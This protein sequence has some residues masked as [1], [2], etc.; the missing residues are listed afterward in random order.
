MV[1]P[2]KFLR[3]DYS[4]MRRVWVAEGYSAPHESCLGS[5]RFWKEF[6]VMRGR[7][8]HARY[9]KVGDY[10][11]RDYGYGETRSVPYNYDW[12]KP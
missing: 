8:T 4:D 12:P 9:T 6:L 2:S 7:R 10:Y 3:R 5:G 11:I 1:F